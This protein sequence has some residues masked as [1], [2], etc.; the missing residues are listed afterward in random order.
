MLTFSDISHIT[1]W[2]ERERERSI[3]IFNLRLDDVPQKQTVMDYGGAGPPPP[4]RPWHAHG[5][6][7]SHFTK[8]RITFEELQD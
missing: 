7:T 1:R 4:P 8:S 3:D 6:P 2:R 5:T